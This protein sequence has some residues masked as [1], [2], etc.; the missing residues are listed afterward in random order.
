MNQLQLIWSDVATSVKDAVGKVASASDAAAQAAAQQQA[1]QIGTQLGTAIQ[2]TGV[3]LGAAVSPAG[4][5]PKFVA[6]FAQN[7]ELVAGVVLVALLFRR[8]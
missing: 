2:Q 4:S 5:S 7:W 8:R 6:W 3:G 1:Q